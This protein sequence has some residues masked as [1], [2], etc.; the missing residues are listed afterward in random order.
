M[1]RRPPRSTLFP[2][3]TLFRS[4]YQHIDPVDVGNDMRMLV[5]DMAGRAS[6]ELKGR[7]LGYDLAGQ[8]DLLTRVT[9]RV[10][11]AEAR[12]YTYDAADASFDLLLREEKYGRRPQ[13][14]RI[15]SWRAIVTHTGNPELI[16]A[17]ATVKLHAGNRRIVKT[18]EG[19]GPVNEIGRAHV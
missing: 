14:F 1:L 2:Y 3:T 11:A 16:D 18:G 17:E 6:I 8:D 9:N 10:K 13:F 12:G 15:E 7:E 4:L 19:N 5:S